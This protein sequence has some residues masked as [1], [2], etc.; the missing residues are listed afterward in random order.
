M[1][2]KNPFDAIINSPKRPLEIPMWAWGFA[3][4]ANNS[5]LLSL[6]LDQR[7]ALWV[8]AVVVINLFGIMRIVKS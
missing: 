6:C 8:S 3:L 5:A 1:T 2:T 7:D 4:W